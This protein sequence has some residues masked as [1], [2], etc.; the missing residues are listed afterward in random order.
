MSP[1]LLLPVALAALLAL[2]VP[3]LIHLARRSEQRPTDFAALRWLRQKPKPRHRVRFDE[4]PLLWLRLLL[5]ALLALWL[6]RPVLF[7][8]ADETPWVAVLPGVDVAQVT[9]SVGDGK[10]RMHWLA[11]GFPELEQAAPTGA[12]PF[13]SLLRQLDAELPANVS[14]TVFV[15]E[16][17][18]GA[19]AMRPQLSREVQW[20]VVVGGMPAQKSAPLTAPVLTVRHAPERADALR[21]LRAAAVA[22][23]QTTSTATNF[24]SGPVA[25][26]L[27]ANARTLVWLAPGPLPPAITDWISKGGTA[28]LDAQ[29]EFKF[30]TP[31]TVY[32]RD[33][34]GA[35]LVEGAAFGEGLVLR[36]TRPLDAA[37]MPQVLEPDFPRELRD[38]LQAPA[39]AP[40]RAMANDYTPITGGASFAQPPRNLQPWLALLVALLLVIERWLATRR[41]RGV[42]P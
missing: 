26:P 10:A 21:Y 36:F 30:S 6:A 12:L 4:W 33:A 14:L 11:P 20:K 8:S 5:L 13:A 9:A 34:V 42:A 40:S 15:P 16:Q 41:S 2:V 37:A 32:W 18:Q 39:P 25:E 35:P 31:T 23:Q 22:W 17:L 29:A 28:L 38:L 27:T 24:S 7:D 1:A 3:L 19:D